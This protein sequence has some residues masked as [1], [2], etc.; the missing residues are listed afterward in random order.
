M[1]FRVESGGYHFYDRV[2]GLHI[3]MNEVSPAKEDW[4]P[5][6][7][8]VSVALTN[9]CDLACHF[10]YAPKSTDQLSF[11]RLLDW[12]KELDKLGVLEVAFGGGDPTFYKKLPDLCKEIWNNTNL[13]IS[14]TTHGHK[15][16]KT[17]VSNLVGNVSIIRFSVDAPEP[18]YS[19]IRGRKL[20][21][22][23]RNIEFTQGKI[24]VGIN[25]VINPLTLPHLDHLAQLLQEWRVTDWLLLP[26]VKDG[27]F[28]LAAEQWKILSKFIN[29]N[30]Q[31][32]R[33]SVNYDAR[34]FL[35]D[36][37]LLFDV[38]PPND[39]AH[40]SAD[41]FLRKTSYERG[42]INLDRATLTEALFQLKEPR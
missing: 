4:S 18:I 25:T 23:V 3:L 6:P 41:G 11:N 35:T 10:C 30:Y 27:Q 5:A 34:S 26:E 33:L 39:Y 21:D 40:I 13:G 31:R 24:H 19:D 12:C 17:L 8:L 9:V 22:V 15:L 29:S 36:C 2:T 32:F 7:S 37:P 16:D 38:E 1:K 42:G 28:I 20:K 14:I